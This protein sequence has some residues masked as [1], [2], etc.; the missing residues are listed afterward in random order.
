MG[1]EELDFAITY[2]SFDIVLLKPY[3]IFSQTQSVVQVRVVEEAQK[4]IFL[5]IIPDNLF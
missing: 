5:P 2:L 1:I 3:Q 4:M